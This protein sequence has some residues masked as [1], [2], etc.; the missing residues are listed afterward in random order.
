MVDI[1]IYSFFMEMFTRQLS[2]LYECQQKHG[3]KLGHNSK[4]SAGGETGMNA[5]LFSARLYFIF[6]FYY[7]PLC[8]TS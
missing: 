6:G 3:G 5:F 8:P 1:V 2:V 7:S 4:D